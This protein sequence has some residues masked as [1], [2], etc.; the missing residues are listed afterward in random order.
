M[1]LTLQLGNN[2]T[3]LYGPNLLVECAAAVAASLFSAASGASFSAA[4]SSASS[5]VTASS[6]YAYA[7]QKSLCF[8]F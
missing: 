3:T 7:S 5:S 2:Y 4:D 8:C 6:T 1:I